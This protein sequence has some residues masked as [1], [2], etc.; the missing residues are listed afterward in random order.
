ME[1]FRP[2]VNGYP[3]RP[4]LVYPP[5]TPLEVG[6]LANPGVDNTQGSPM[7]RPPGGPGGGKLGRV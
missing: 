2:S 7:D 6:P 1:F 4:H 5:W 3:A